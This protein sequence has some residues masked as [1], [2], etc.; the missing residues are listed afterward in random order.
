MKAAAAR[1]APDIV[2][3]MSAPQLFGPWFEGSSWDPWKT[4]LR[5]AYALPMTAGEKA[6]LRSVA[7]RDPPTKPV[8]ELWCVIG[9]G[10]G[11]DS[12]A[13]LIAAY[14]GALFQRHGKLRPGESASV[15]CV[16][17]DRTTAKIV[18][19][20][21]RT[22]FEDI[23][24]LKQMIRRST[25]TG[26]ELDNGVEIAVH[27][28]SYRAVR[29]RSLLLCILDE[30]AFFRDENSSTPDEE[31]YRA[32]LPGLA[33]MPGSMLIGISTPH[34]KAGL[35]F[36]QYQRHY[37][38]DGD[39]LVIKAP[40]I[41][42]NP[43]LDRGVIDRAVADDPEARAEWLAEFRDDISQWATRELIEAATDH[44]ILTRPA[45]V[46][47]KYTAFVDVSGG[48][49]DSFALAIAHMEGNVVTLDCVTEIPAPFA[50][51]AAVDHAV[52]VMREYHCYIAYGD[53]FG[54]EWVTQSFARRGVRYEPP[55]YNAT[56][57]YIN[58]LPL[59]TSARV[60]LVDH[61]RTLSQLMALERTV[62]PAGREK[63]DHPRGGHDDCAVAA[64]GACVLAA[65]TA[66][67]SLN[68]TRAAIVRGMMPSAQ[69]LA[70]HF[71]GY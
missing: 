68:I 57:I 42:F 56:E 23:P 50:A 43:T 61:R 2:Q 17:V 60:R 5:A 45:R 18:L 34:A 3:A 36:K 7:D 13:S 20:Y 6:F 55:G 28:N 53:A 67:F 10:G 64:A 46:G 32:V 31:T 15:M 35:L 16:A 69:A 54:A 19:D 21:T 40:S 1:A 25:A 9:R 30:V 14:A 66:R 33:R 22:Y 44:N 62:L 70:R 8:R 38:K 29:G 58:F 27:A 39:V 71:G 26:F 51:D 41:T 24:P 4:I 12:I 48:R 49:S 63:I 65:S 52:N 47:I 11:K 37:G 59:L